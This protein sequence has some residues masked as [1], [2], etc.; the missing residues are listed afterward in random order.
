MEKRGDRREMPERGGERTEV[1]IL[2]RN[3]GNRLKQESKP[4]EKHKKRKPRLERI[5]KPGARKYLL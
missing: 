1:G 2:M 3:F 5:D 4:M